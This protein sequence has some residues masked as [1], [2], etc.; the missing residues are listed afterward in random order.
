M[1]MQP[2]LIYLAQ[3]RPDMT[4]EQFIARWRQHGLLGMSKPRWAN[5]ARYVHCDVLDAGTEFPGISNDYDGVGLIWHKSQE[6]RS[7]HRADVSSQREMEA[8]E[9]ETFREP[10]VNFCL[11]AEEIETIYA[12]ELIENPVKLFRFLRCKDNPHRGGLQREI[13]DRRPQLANL[14]RR[15]RGWPARHCVNASLRPQ[16]EG[17]TAWRLDADCVEEFW[18][19]NLDTL[20][21]FRRRC[22]SDPT[23]LSLGA[24]RKVSLIEIV[25]NEVMLHDVSR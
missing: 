2:K 8:D 9:R 20:A 3:R 19:E 4:R 12:R 24:Y 6:A 10:V 16:S 25:T 11:L 21:E 5:I 23:L 13:I 15:D 14:T 18:F 7:A 22:F 17:R 1:T